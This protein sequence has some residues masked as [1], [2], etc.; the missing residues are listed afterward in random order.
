MRSISPF[1]EPIARIPIILN[2][3]T[4][5]VEIFYGCSNDPLEAG[6]DILPDLI[7]DINLSKGYPVL[8]ARIAEYSGSGYRTYCGWIQVVTNEYLTQTDTGNFVSSRIKEVDISPAM[9]QARM[10]FCCV[11][12]LPQFYDAPCCNLGNHHHQKWIANTF[13]TTVP[14]RSLA[15]PIS[16]ILSFRWGYAEDIELDKT[17]VSILPFEIMDSTTW[18]ET[19]L[20]LRTKYKAWNF[21]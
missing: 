16:S 17:K 9:R 13:L 1:A 4:G 8:Y 5:K 19:V 21:I 2:G 3:R 20:L 10:P 11:G 15:Q 12:N 7:F 18:N 6:F 14:S